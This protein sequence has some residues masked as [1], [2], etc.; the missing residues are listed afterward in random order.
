L[1]LILIKKIEEI[2]SKVKYLNLDCN[3]F[4]IIE[5][6]PNNIEELELG[7]NFNLEL[8]NLPNSIKVIKFNKDSYYDKEL[9]NLHP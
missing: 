4:D 5:N 9:N 3:D 7:L 1:V 6:L 2:P 8:N